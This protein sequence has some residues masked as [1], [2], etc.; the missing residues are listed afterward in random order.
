M[1]PARTTTRALV[2]CDVI[3]TKTHSMRG[4]RDRP[5]PGAQGSWSV[6]VLAGRGYYPLWPLL[7]SPE[8]CKS[9]LRGRRA[10]VPGG[11]IDNRHEK[12]RSARLRRD[13]PE[14]VQTVDA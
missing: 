5:V 9:G 11:L 10:T 8:R 3:E 7:L 2:H 6:G 14:A 13:Q 4:S 12:K 1:M